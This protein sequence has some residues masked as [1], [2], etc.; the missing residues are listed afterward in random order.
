M[1]EVFTVTGMTCSHCEAAVTRAIRRLDAQARI[2][3]DRGRNRVEVVQSSQPRE[4]LARAIRDE[5]YDV[6]E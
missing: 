6:G 3:I 1:S 4:T 5:G 2:S